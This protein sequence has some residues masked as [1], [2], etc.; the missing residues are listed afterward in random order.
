MPAKLHRQPRLIREPMAYGSLR[1]YKIK[2]QIAELEAG[3]P[4]TLTDISDA[5]SA[6]VAASD[7]HSQYVA[8]DPA[9]R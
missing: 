2:K 3:D 5:V 9:L 4:A 8:T 6:H 1:A 7:P